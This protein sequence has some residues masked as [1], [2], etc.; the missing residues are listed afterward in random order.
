M[1]ARLSGHILS[2]AS[3]PIA[4]NSL[5]PKR[6]GRGLSGI[7]LGPPLQEASDQGTLAGWTRLPAGLSVPGWPKTPPH[8]DTRAP[9]SAHGTNLLG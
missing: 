9:P 7:H 4:R 3:G 1:E 2:E 6:A 8:M 5:G